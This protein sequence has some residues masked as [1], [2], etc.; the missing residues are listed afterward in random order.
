MADDPRDYFWLITHGEEDMSYWEEE[1][2][3]YRLLD[4]EEPPRS[5]LP[6]SP[7]RPQVPAMALAVSREQAAALLGY[8]LDHYER[9][10]EPNLRTVRLGRRVTVP[11]RELERWVEDHAA[12]ALK[13]R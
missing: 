6:S 8:S 10:V 5:A 13:G 4:G 3:L 12:Q 1:A 11:V 9:H 2:A 7:E